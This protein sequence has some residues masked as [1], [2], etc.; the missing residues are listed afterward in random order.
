MN[1]L[2]YQCAYL[3]LAAIFVGNCMADSCWLAGEWAVVYTQRHTAGLT[4]GH[5][6]KFVSEEAAKQMA[7]LTVGF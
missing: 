6:Q 7:Y 5:S 2:F 3:L 4:Q 1:C